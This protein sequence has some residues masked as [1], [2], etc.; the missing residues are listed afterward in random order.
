MSEVASVFRSLPENTR[1]KVVR[2]V[3]LDFP[4][5]HPQGLVKRE[6]TFFMTSVD[7]KRE[8]G[9]LHQ[10]DAQG[11]ELKTTQLAAK[12]EFHP[13]GLDDDGR[14]LWTAVAE[15]K[16]DSHATVLRIDPETLEAR[17]VLRTDDHLGAVVHAS[18]RHELVAANWDS[19]EFLTFDDSGHPR[20]VRPNPSRYVGL[21][22]C[23]YLGDGFLLGS[24]V[25]DDKRGALELHDLASGQL[26]HRVKVD[27]RSPQGTLMTQNPVAFEVADGKLRLYCAPDDDR[28]TLFILEPTG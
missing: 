12:P 24:G 9:Y 26:V 11:H 16:A 28:G 10:F 13:G 1:W 14:H 21:Q 23:K 4:V 3:K 25:H 15:Y 8:K 20:G 18:D 2:E 19:E 6:D 22:D 5:H 27:L 7:K 17:P